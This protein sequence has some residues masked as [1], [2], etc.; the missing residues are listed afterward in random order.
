M[1]LEYAMRM[2][3]FDFNTFQLDQYEHLEQLENGD[4]NWVIP[5]KILAFSSPYDDAK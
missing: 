2:G 3:W 4:I 1:G 5:G